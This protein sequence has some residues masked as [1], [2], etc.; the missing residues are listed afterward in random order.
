MT[1]E[2]LREDLIKYLESQ[3]CEMLAKEVR[4]W[5]SI[6]DLVYMDKERK[7]ICVELKLTDWKKVVQQALKIKNHTPLVYIA[8]PL[9]ATIGKRDRIQEI[10]KEKGLGLFWF[11]GDGRWDIWESPQEKI[12]P[13]HEDWIQYCNKKL[14]QKLYRHYH[15]TFIAPHLGKA[16]DIS[17][18]YHYK[19]KNVIW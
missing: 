13:R 11:R 8:M 9:P 1:E 18:N 10:V 12:Y 6:I 3:N 19:T 4:L 17:K 15:F 14:E 16:A 5:S 7:F 2:M